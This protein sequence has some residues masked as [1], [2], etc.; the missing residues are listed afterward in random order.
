MITKDKITEIFCLADDFC[1]YFSSGLKKR[2][3]CDG[4]VHRNKPGRLS[5]AEVITI[6]I[7]SQQGHPLPQ[8]LLHPVCMQASDAPVPQ[9]GIIQQVSGVAEISAAASVDIHQ[10]GA[11]GHM[12]RHCLRWLHPVKDLQATAD[13][14]P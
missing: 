5:D 14:H 1:K 8:T 13:T 3:I 6:L 9:D 10:G 7:L 12:H 2:R 4:K 11:A